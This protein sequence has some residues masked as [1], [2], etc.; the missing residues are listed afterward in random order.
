M[1]KST[2]HRPLGQ[3]HSQRRL[4]AARDET[5]PLEE[6]T[7]Q[8]AQEELMRIVRRL[9][10]EDFRRDIRPRLA[11]LTPEQRA[12]VEGELVRLARLVQEKEATG[13]DVP[14][15]FLAVALDRPDQARRL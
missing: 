14:I 3:A 1:L 12:I 4:V 15:D 10:F 2:F 8:A 6:W 5:P 7:R 13:S 11:R 9:P